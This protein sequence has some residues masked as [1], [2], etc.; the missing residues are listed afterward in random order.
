MKK[1]NIMLFFILLVSGVFLGLDCLAEPGQPAAVTNH[2]RCAV[3]GMFVAKY[4]EWVAQIELSDGKIVMFD[5]PKDMLAFYFA[6]EEYGIEGAR[7]EHM[8]VKDYYSQQWLD[9]R[10]AL[11]VIGSDVYGPMGEE[12]VPFDGRE[13]ADNFL[14]DH[15]GKAI[16]SLEDVTPG[17]VRDMQKGHKMKMKKKQ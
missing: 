13:A 12:F 9:G 14:K 2:D 4:P 1:L 6:P 17:L 5:G 16:V 15:H 3:C 11:Y 10:E 7:M 8:H